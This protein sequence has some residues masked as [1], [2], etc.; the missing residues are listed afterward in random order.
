MYMLAGPNGAGKSTLYENRIKPSVKAPFI[1][2][3][4]IQ[5]DELKDPSMQASYKAADIAEAR[6][7]E[8]LAKGRDFVSESTFSHASKLSLIREAK[9]AGFRVVLYHVNV[10]S[11]DLSVARVARRTAEGGHNVPENK[12]RERYVRNQAL[13]KAA[14]LDADRAFV[15]DNSRLNKPPEIAIKFKL[16]KVVQV[17]DRVPA[18]VRELY[19]D[20]LAIFSPARLNPAAASF[21]DAK[22]IAAK[23]GGPDAV[24]RIPT[25]GRDSV[26]AGPLVGETAEHWL[27][28]VDEH[29]FVA[30]F[31]T[32]L[33][34]HSVALHTPY[35]I[36]Y[37]KPGQA[38]LREAPSAVPGYAAAFR[39]VLANE[40]SQAAAL[41]RHP[42]LRATFNTLSVAK[43]E[44]AKKPDQ[45][46]KVAQRLQGEL[47]AGKIH[48]SVAARSKPVERRR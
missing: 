43:I 37:P 33:S 6:R 10:R 11:A 34:A 32:A 8:H 3:D 2:A 48:T 19:A 26:T 13:I 4:I 45:L 15:Y 40:L 44:H 20:E 9:E 24:V 21:A 28:R 12:I 14:V 31:K 39:A 46:A 7:R 1:N 47:D 30:H 29:T 17:S 25:H 5:L 18:W 36:G 41:K 22:E 35:E 27:Q 38:A 23:L 16:G 42:E